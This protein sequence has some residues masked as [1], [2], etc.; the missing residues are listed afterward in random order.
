MM[1]TAESASVA[2]SSESATTRQRI[3]FW[4]LL[5]LIAFLGS[6][7]AFVGFVTAG[8]VWFTISDALG[9]IQAITIVPLILGLDQL[10]N[11]EETSLA[12]VGKWLGLTG[13]FLVGVGSIVL[14]TSDVSHQFVPA[15]GGLGMQFVG[16]GLIGGW[17]LAQGVISRRTGFLGRR[18]T[19][20]ALAVGVGFVIGILGAP[21]G[22][23][24]IATSLGGSIALIGFIVWTISIRS[25]MAATD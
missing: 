9:L 7:I 3:R 10:L 22:P 19:W 12:R 24:S 13:C 18:T 1:T 5:A 16:F 20:S 15:G 6:I 21:F 17:F 23:E 25:E 11:T 14:L 2:N 4:A 8:G